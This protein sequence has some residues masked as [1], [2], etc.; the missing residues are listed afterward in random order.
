MEWFP[1]ICAFIGGV[2]VSLIDF[3]L[4]RKALSKP[5]KMNVFLLV[6]TAV[7]ALAVA[8]LYFIGRAAGLSLVPFMIAGALGLTVGLIVTTALLMKKQRSGKE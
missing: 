4:M 3:A 6:R 1:C 7:S 2:G 8:L 5:D